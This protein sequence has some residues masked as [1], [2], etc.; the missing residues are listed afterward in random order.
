MRASTIDAGTLRAHTRAG[1]PLPARGRT[2]ER[3]SHLAALGEQDLPLAKL[4]EPHHDAIA[5]LTELGAP[6][7]P[8]GE[9][10]ELWAVWAAEPPFAVLEA[11]QRADGWFLTGRKAFCSGATLVTHALVT[12][13]THDGARLFAIDVQA[14]GIT[15]DPEGHAWHGSGMARAATVTLAFDQVDAVPVGAPGAYTE[16]PGFW[17][18]AIGIAAVWFGGARGVANVLEDA[19]GGLDAHGLAHLGAVRA[20]LE[21][22]ALIFTA[23]ARAADADDLGTRDVERLALVVRQRT[24]DVVDSVITRVGRALGPAPLVFDADHGARVDDL[25]VFVRQHHAE[26]D[27]EHLGSLE[28]AD[29]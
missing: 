5:I 26:R 23:V 22:L 20:D 24:S 29:G 14:G 4:V 16:R 8:G 27:L 15:P 3:W 11:D 1:W 12:A 28:R 25:Q 18:G 17:W 6:R 13:R 7:A 2:A 10:D 9:S 21:G 19:R